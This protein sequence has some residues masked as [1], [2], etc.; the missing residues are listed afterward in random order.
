MIQMPERYRN[1]IYTT[2]GIL[3]TSITWL[4]I[5]RIFMEISEKGNVD[6][7]KSK[8]SYVASLWQDRSNYSI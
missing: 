8:K 6:V 7:I 1:S 2:V 3:N 4:G 5:L